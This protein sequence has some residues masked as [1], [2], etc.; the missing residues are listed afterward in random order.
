MNWDFAFQA[1]N[2]WALIMWAMLILLPRNALAGAAVFYG[3]VGM[4]C[5]AYTLF[6][7]L[8]VGGAVDPVS[9]SEGAGASFTTI[10]GVRGLFSTDGGVTIGWIHYLAFDLFAGLWISKDADTKGFSRLVQSPVLLLTFIAGPAGL[11][12]WFI[13]REK[14]ARAAAGPRRRFT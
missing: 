3:G 11:L 14:R 5:F 6:M 1:A 4:L 9:Q 7:G 13:V 10:A 12:V 2:I 8:V